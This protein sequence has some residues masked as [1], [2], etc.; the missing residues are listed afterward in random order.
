MLI[1]T[2]VNSTNENYAEIIYVSN[3]YPGSL[4]VCLVIDIKRKNITN[5]LLAFCPPGVLFQVN[6]K[7]Y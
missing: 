7:L 2:K 1:L 3:Y 5:S 4:T 6:V